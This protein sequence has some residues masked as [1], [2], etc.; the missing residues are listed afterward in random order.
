MNSIVNS[1]VGHSRAWWAPVSWKTG[2]PTFCATLALTS[3][4]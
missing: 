1:A 4:P 2:L 3:T